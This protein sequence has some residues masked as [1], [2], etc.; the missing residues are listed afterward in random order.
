M[1]PSGTSY[2]LNPGCNVTPTMPPWTGIA[3][4]TIAAVQIGVKYGCILIPWTSGWRTLQNFGHL[5]NLLPWLGKCP[6]SKWSEFTGPNSFNISA[7]DAR[8][9]IS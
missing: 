5:K 8:Q 3:L 4:S 9:S 2:F 7:G 1:N 6:K